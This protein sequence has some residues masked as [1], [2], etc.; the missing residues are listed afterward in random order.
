[1]TTGD[2][3]PAAVDESSDVI[4]LPP[5]VPVSGDHRERSSKKLD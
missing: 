2:A 1:M 3:A 4:S 5:Q